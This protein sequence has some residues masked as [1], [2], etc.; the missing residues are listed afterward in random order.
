MTQQAML[1]ELEAAAARLAVKVS[2]ESLATSVGTGGLC[3]VRGEYR[4]IIDK[5][6]QVGDRVS[7]LAQALAYLPTLTIE[8]PEPTMKF[9]PAVRHLI[10]HYAAMRRAS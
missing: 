10:R 4:V 8:G 9:S 5:R 7:A 1:E 2:Y 3:R 6:T